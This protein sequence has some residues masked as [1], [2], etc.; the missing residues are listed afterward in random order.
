MASFFKLTYM[1]RLQFIKSILVLP[2][3]GSNITSLS[4]PSLPKEFPYTRE[5]TIDY[6]RSLCNK[7]EHSFHMLLISS[8][9]GKENM[10]ENFLIMKNQEVWFGLDSGKPVINLEKCKDLSDGTLLMIRQNVECKY[11]EIRQKS[12][13]RNYGRSIK[14]GTSSQK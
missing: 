13:S 4:L 7:G 2:F 9:D 1:Q 11:N 14:M 12:K 8:I 3:I 5:G 10:F 6:F